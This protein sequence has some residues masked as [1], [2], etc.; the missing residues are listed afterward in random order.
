MTVDQLIEKLTLF[1]GVG[2]G[3]ADVVVNEMADPCFADTILS[4]NTAHD[5][6]GN[7]YVA[8][9]PSG[10]AVELDYGE[11]VDDDWTVDE[12]DNNGP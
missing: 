3:N 9:E 1:K 5:T 10:M 6:N 4:A 11:D 8:L 12:D 7:L 2:Y